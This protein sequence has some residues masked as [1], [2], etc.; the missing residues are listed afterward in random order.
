MST[1]ATE[2]VIGIPAQK[3]QKILL[4]KGTYFDIYTDL[5][6][7]VIPLSAPDSLE[8][9]DLLMDA[10]ETDSLEKFSLLLSLGVPIISE[11]RNC[12]MGRHPDLK[13]V[14]SPS[15]H[16]SPAFALVY[17]Q[18]IMSM[19][20][21]PMSVLRAHVRNSPGRLNLFKSITDVNVLAALH[22]HVGCAPSYSTDVSDEVLMI[23]GRAGLL[24]DK[25]SIRTRILEKIKCE[26]ETRKEALLKATIE[27]LTNDLAV[28]KTTIETL[29]EQLSVAEKKLSDATGDLE[30]QTKNLRMVVLAALEK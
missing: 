4:S 29:T 2:Q 8:N 26:D 6:Q 9:A 17:A 24:S 13:S 14:L 3:A 12:L 5:A 25:P 19:E 15:F 20:D 28:A 23:C 16:V 7:A 10:I 1:Q 21:T 11:S 27:T 22:L 30:R 18:K